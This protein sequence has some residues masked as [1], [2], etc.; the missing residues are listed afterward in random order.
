MKTTIS[1][2]SHL[3]ISI[4]TFDYNKMVAKPESYKTIEFDY[5]G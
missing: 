3:S 5:L 2:F 4:S 1:A